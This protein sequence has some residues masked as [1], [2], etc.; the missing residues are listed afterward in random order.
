MTLY[1]NFRAVWQKILRIRL[2]SG[3][4]PGSGDLKLRIFHPDN[5]Y[6]WLI[7]VDH[8]KNPVRTGTMKLKI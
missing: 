5:A 2:M 7:R 4:E 6:H 3:P 8:E 1:S